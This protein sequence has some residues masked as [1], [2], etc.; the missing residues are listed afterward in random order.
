MAFRPGR[1]PH[2]EDRRRRLG[3]GMALSGLLWPPL[4]PLVTFALA[5]LSDRPFHPWSSLTTGVL[6]GLAWFLLGLATRERSR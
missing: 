6:V 4:F 1:P 3:W 5:R 2:D